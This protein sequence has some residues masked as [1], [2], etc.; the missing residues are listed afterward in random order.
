[1][2]EINTYRDL[3][4]WQAGMDTIALTY[5]L[6]SDFPVEERYGL[7]S[8]M[9]RAS[10]SIPSNVAEG[11]GVAMPRWSLRHIGTAIGSSLELETQVEAAVRLGFVPRER[12]ASLADCLDRVQ[13]LLYG[14]RRER[15]RRIGGKVAGASVLLLAVAHVLA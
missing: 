7:V 1:M 14:M 9:R 15:L 12:T 11:Y 4:A 3:H 2:G 5:E 6:T 8:Q 13:K 10:V